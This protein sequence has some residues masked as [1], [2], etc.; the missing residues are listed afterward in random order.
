[1]YGIPDRYAPRRRASDRA[2]PSP[3]FGLVGN[4]IWRL[5]GSGS[6]RHVW[7]EKENRKKGMVS[8]GMTQSLEYLWLSELSFLLKGFANPRPVNRGGGGVV[9]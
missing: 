1:M 4:R 8:L 5:P 3:S 9:P 7:Q 6:W 2:M